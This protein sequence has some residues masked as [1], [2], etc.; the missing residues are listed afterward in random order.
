MATDPKARKDFVAHG[1]PEHAALLGLK[2]AAKDDE[3][4]YE[5]YTLVDLTVYGPNASDKFLRAMLVQRVN[6]LKSK[7]A[8][9][10]HAPPLWVP[11]AAPLD[12][13]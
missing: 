6:E 3:L 12:T 8:V 2:K 4:E 11:A 1:S 7:P 10:A 5:G 9:P 13:P